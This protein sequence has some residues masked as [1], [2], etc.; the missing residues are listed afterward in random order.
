MNARLKCP[1]DSP[2]RDIDERTTASDA[3]VKLRGNVA[4][5]RLEEGGVCRPR[6]AN[7]STSS[8]ATL[9]RLMSTTGETYVSICCISVTF[10]SI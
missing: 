3:S 2:D 1:T 5:L 6:L 10:A 9:N 8:G 7:W 4:R